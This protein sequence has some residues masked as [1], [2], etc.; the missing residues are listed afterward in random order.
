M[1]I[2]CGLTHEFSPRK[3]FKT[4]FIVLIMR[5]IATKQE[6]ERRKRRNQFIVGGVL[7]FI[8]FFSVAGYSFMGG[9]E[10]SNKK[11][12]IY[13][14]FEFVKQ[15]NFWL[16][17]MENF[18]FAFQYNPTQVEKM[19]SGVNLLNTY[20]E[21]PLYVFSENKDA[22]AEIYR[23]LHP[24]FN[25]IVL[26]MQSAC[27]DEERCGEDLPIK[28]CGGEEYNFIIIEESEKIGIEQ[29]ESCVFIRGPQENLTM[30]ADEFLFKMLGVE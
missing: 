9:D 12:I 21:K 30:I 27:F 6:E 20:Y 22:E 17:G 23:N 19:Y 5:R 16:L 1:N 13:N 7:I 11:K 4:C 10:E 25:P 29:N 28:T 8:M 2:C 3:V 15:N 14:G 18:V 26:R 24:Q